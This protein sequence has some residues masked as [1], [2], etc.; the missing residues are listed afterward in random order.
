MQI[1]E[2]I[3]MEEICGKKFQVRLI[4]KADNDKAAFTHFLH[5]QNGYSSVALKKG[6]VSHFKKALKYKFPKES[7]SNKIAEEAL[8]GMLF[9][10]RNEIPFPHKIRVFFLLCFS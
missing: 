2:N 3:T 7:I 8:Q 5:N 10:Y 4:E 6:A 1:V 9:D